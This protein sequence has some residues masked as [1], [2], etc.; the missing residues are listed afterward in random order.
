[1]TEL[2]ALAEATQRYRD[3]K[4]AHDEAQKAVA[5]AAVDALKAGHLPTEVVACSP[6]TA[7]YIRR[8]ARA[9]GV[10]PAPPGPKHR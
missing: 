8:L 10:E 2:D 7:A 1:M 3:T 5:E 6:F 9:A 4:T